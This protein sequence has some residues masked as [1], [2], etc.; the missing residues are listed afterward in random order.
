MNSLSKYHLMN[1]PALPNIDVLLI[2]D[3]HSKEGPFGAKSIGEVSFVP[4]AA[5]VM[6][7]VNQALDSDMGMI[8]MSSDR[9]VE[10]LSKEEH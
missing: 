4:S 10:Y 2:Q 5:A 9:I 6:A 8:P 7:A 3:G 1:A